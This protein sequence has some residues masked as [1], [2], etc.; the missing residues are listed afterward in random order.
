MTSFV[1]AR[2]TGVSAVQFVLQADGVAEPEEPE[3]AS[4]PEPE[5]TLWDK[6]TALFDFR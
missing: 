6:F 4:E 5:Q 2:N 1:S 3:E